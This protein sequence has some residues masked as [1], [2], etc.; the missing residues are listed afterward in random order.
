MPI[1]RLLHPTSQGVSKHHSNVS[2]VQ[3]THRR[4]PS[5]SFFC[6][7]F[8]LVRGASREKGNKAQAMK[9]L[10]AVQGRLGN[11]LGGAL[12]ELGGG[13]GSDLVCVASKVGIMVS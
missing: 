12:A 11:G 4:E 2:V 7:C 13:N 9:L 1:P 6:F 8:P 10:K 5:L 3:M